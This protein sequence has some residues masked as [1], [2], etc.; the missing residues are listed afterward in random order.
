VNTD[1][2]SL[3][4]LVTNLRGWAQELGFADAGVSHLEL[5]D[6][7]AHLR[8]WLERGYHGGMDYLTRSPEART[9]PAR[10]RPSALSV[11]S[12]R[13]EYRPAAMDAQSVL[14]DRQ[15]AYI[16]RYA[17]G[18][19]YHR[20]VR[21]RLLRLARRLEQAI[22]PHGY[23]VLADSAPMLEKALARNA[24]LGWIGKN[25]LL[26]R[27][28]AGSWF[29]LGEILTDL[30]L[31]GDTRKPADNLCGRCSA[32]IKIC[33]TQAIVAPY[34]LDARRCISYL[35]IEHRGAIPEDLRPL[36]GNR[37]FG[38]DDCQLA[39]PWNREAAVSAEPDF[40]PRHGLDGARL[41]ELFN[42]TEAEWLERTEGMALRRLDHVRWLRNLAVAMGNAAPDAEIAAALQS[43]ADHPDAMV[44]E[45]VQWA[46]R[47]QL[48]PVPALAL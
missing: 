43:R 28:D 2:R 22:G 14:E 27:R 30:P 8:R 33:P 25:T 29:F 6:D 41:V 34:T 12:L 10:L 15:R 21:A 18:R 4:E 13:M 9:E 47:R 32:C 39:C 23:R 19:D 26:L 40:A 38:C 5:G 3:A 46:L 31:P 11:I 42:W 48:Q 45:H 1:A 7:L 20:V 17:L 16:S 24:N 36:M 35:T 37:V 44:R